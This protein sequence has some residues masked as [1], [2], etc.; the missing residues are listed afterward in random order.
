MVHMFLH[1]L[2]M[3]EQAWLSVNSHLD[4][5]KTKTYE[6]RRKVLRR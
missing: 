6:K 1:V 4:S 3:I 5:K 2:G